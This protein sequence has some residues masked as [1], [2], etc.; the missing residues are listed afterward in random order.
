MDT[1][2]AISGG[3]G[4]VA[5]GIVRMSGDDSIALLS[6]VFRPLAGTLTPRRMVYGEFLGADGAVIDRG[7]AA[8]FPGP[9]SYTG[10]D[11]AELYTHGSPLVEQ[12]LLEALFAHGARMAEP[13]EFTK[14]AFL[15]GRMDLSEA[16]AVGDLL[17]A[18]TETGVKNAVAQLSGA[19]R[20]RVEPIYDG[21]MAV[22]SRFYAVV[23]YPDEDIRDLSREEI[24]TALDKAETELAA[25]LDTFRRGT[26]L[27]NGIATAIIGAPNAGKSSLLNALL[28]YDRAI[29]TDIPGTTRDTVEEKA[30][31][32]G[33]LL[34][35]IDTA[36]LHESGDA[37]ER[38]GIE[39]SRAAVDNAELI[40]VLAD[41]SRPFTEED[42]EAVRLARDSGKPWLF[43]QTKIDIVGDSVSV[44]IVGKDAPKNIG[45]SAVTG[46]G[47]K[48]L[49]NAVKELFP[50]GNESPGTLLTNERQRDS[51]SRAL[52]ALRRARAAYDALFTPDAILTDMEDALAALGELTGKTAKEDLVATIFSKFCVGK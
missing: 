52:A 18:E 12:L 8:A 4:V 27:K 33:V 42:G 28:G 5:I 44:G 15:H 14:R 9:N 11:M 50:Q 16:E 2:A 1:I 23:D 48:E 46:E 7:M 37:V 31:L 43:L 19:L 26:V 25:L 34:R 32:G 38:I 39:R 29:V 24:G 6:R 21:L 36:G 20:R 10:E 40:F 3:H 30:V 22:A 13:G 47:L 35:L 17:Y 45:I 51:V 41:G 49:E